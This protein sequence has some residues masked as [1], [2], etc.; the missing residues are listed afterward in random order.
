MSKLA[1]LIGILFP[2]PDAAQAAE[3]VA[4]QAPADAT[5]AEMAIAA[6]DA[7]P[8]AEGAGMRYRGIELLLR[9]FEAAN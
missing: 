1:L 7:L 5:I 4:A 8:D 2:H 3:P 9:K 6:V